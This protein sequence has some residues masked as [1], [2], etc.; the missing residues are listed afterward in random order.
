MYD[1]KY[2]QE[3]KSEYNQNRQRYRKKSV[4]RIPLDVKTDWYN[5]LDTYCKERNLK[6][7][8]FIKEACERAAQADGFDGFE[9]YHAKE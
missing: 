4:K 9:K 2:Y 6:L 7:N 1:E 3:H 8:T 5:I